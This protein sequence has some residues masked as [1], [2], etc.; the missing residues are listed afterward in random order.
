MF[1]FSL[2]RFRITGPFFLPKHAAGWVAFENAFNNADFI[3]KKIDINYQKE[4]SIFKL[5]L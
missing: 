4:K 5:M 2:F 1:N 3:E